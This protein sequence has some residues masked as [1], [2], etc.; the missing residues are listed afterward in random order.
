M[1]SGRRPVEMAGVVRVEDM[2][3]EWEGQGVLGVDKRGRGLEVEGEAMHQGRD[4]WV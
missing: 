4:E 1:G 2:E 3:W